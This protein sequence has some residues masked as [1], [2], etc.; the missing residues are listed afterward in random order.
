MGQ[1]DKDHDGPAC[2][3][4]ASA[5]AFHQLPVAHMLGIDASLPE[6]QKEQQRKG[7]PQVEPGHVEMGIPGKGSPQMVS[8]EFGEQDHQPV[9]YGIDGG[10]EIIQVMMDKGIGTGFSEN[11]IGHG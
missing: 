4:A 3:G 1:I 11:S 10:Q 5:Y 8:Q 6:K 2:I 7:D 9:C